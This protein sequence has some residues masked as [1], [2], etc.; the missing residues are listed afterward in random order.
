ML[1]IPLINVI[2]FSH[3]NS[4][5]KIKWIPSDVVGLCCAIK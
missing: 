4:N 1:N 5:H 3:D 2:N